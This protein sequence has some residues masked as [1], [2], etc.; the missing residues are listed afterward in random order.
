MTLAVFVDDPAA[1]P[2]DV[3]AKFIEPAGFEDYRRRLWGAEPI[4]TRAALL[5]QI[6]DDLYV[7]PDQF[8]EFERQCQVVAASADQIADELGW[9]NG[10]AIRGYMQNFLAAL[11]FA[12]AKNSS[13]I[14]IG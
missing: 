7:A 2:D 9:E 12:R 11:A 3:A 5:G 13:Q 1:D 4:R 8:D 10:D 14:Y 6:A